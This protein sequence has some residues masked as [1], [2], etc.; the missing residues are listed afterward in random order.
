[1]HLQALDSRFIYL[2]KIDYIYVEGIKLLKTDIT[3]LMSETCHNILLKL[4]AINSF[5]SFC[6]DLKKISSKTQR[7]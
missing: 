2:L 7:R 3:C 1:M 5:I 6:D 4:Q